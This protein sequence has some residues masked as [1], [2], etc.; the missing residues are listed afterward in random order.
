[1]VA[2][3][4]AKYTKPSNLTIFF[5]SWRIWR[6]FLDWKISINQ[7]FGGNELLEV[8]SGQCIY[9]ISL[10]AHILFSQFFDGSSNLKAGYKK[11]A[12]HDAFNSTYTHN[13]SHN[14]YAIFSPLSGNGH[15]CPLFASG[16]SDTLYVHPARTEGGGVT[17]KELFSRWYLGL[18]V[19]AQLQS[20]TARL[21]VI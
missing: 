4:F 1:M 5:N 13:S 16:T 6:I 18:P 7:I 17:G 12:I 14:I 8:V 9:C 2:K 15:H 19:V 20:S 10:C 11:D 3:W 21:L